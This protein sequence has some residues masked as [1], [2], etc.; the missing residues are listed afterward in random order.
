MAELIDEEMK[1]EFDEPCEPDCQPD[2]EMD[3]FHFSTPLLEKDAFTF[4]P[5]TNPKFNSPG[6]SRSPQ[7][8]GFLDGFQELP[9]TPPRGYFS[10]QQ[11]ARRASSS[12]LRS[13]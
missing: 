1:E 4:N 12:Q 8:R 6:R 10:A 11:A 2:Q 9:R 7:P 5:H 13:A 3:D